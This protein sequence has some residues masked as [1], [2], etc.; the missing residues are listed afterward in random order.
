LLILTGCGVGAKVGARLFARP[1]A[2]T[3]PRGGSPPGPVCP[4]RS[5]SHATRAD[6]PRSVPPSAVMS[7]AS[8]RS[9]CSVA[10]K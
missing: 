7:S 9:R 5:S 3:R 8:S 1:H 2:R 6:W 4:A 10:W